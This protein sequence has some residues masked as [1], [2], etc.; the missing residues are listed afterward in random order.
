MNLTINQADSIGALA[1]ILC[2]LHCFATPFLILALAGN[3]SFLGEAP[4][5]W[6]LINYLF[7]IISFLA[8]YRSSQTTS[9]R[10]MKPLLWIGWSILAF[11]IIN[12]HI[13]LLELSEAVTYA[14]SVILVVLHLYNRKYCQCRTNHCCMDE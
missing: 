9:N 2:M 11:V 13:S 12:E 8:V 14:S 5:W 10:F 7:L 3:A 1:V 6:L 4:T